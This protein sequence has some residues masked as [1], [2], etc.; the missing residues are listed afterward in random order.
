MPSFFIINNENIKYQPN[1][2]CEI[3]NLIYNTQIKIQE[4][5]KFENF[6][7]NLEYFNNLE[8]KKDSDDKLS[9]YS[10]RSSFSIK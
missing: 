1:N 10:D 8:I 7:N 4:L 5:G 6:I 3:E 9:L 2:F